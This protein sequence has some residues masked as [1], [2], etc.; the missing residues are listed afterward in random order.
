MPKYYTEPVLQPLSG[1]CFAHATTNLEDGARFDVST[2]GFLSDQHQKAFSDVRV[3]HPNAKSYRHLQF[4][5]AC[6]LHENRE[7]M[8]KEFGKLSMVLLL[9]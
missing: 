8:T 6:R 4:P 3:F 5:Y 1:E 9:H 7:H 2:Q